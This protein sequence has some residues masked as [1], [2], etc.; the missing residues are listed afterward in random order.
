MRE[1]HGTSCQEVVAALAVVSA[2]ALR[3]EGEPEPAAR[4]VSPRAP[5]RAPPQAP[6]AKAAETRLQTMVGYRARE[7][8]VSAGTLTF[9]RARAFNLYA[10]AQLGLLPST[11]VLTRSSRTHDTSSTLVGSLSR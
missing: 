2:L 5:P 11:F 6:P 3:G 1:V 4:A 7:V 9:D 8:P 10:G